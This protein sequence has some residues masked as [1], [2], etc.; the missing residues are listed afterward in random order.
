MVIQGKS[1]DLQQHQYNECKRSWD[2]A[3]I[4]HFQG[5]LGAILHA[6]EFANNTPHLFQVK[7]DAKGT[8]IAPVQLE[9]QFVQDGK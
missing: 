2:A 1:E 6:E 7:T 8:I 4:T 9:L 5:V 3:H